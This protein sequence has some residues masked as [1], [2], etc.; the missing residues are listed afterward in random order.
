MAENKNKHGLSRYIPEA[1]KREVRQRCGFG[2]V[3]CG[4]GFY[5]YEHFNPDFADAKEHHP[6]G[7][8]LLCSQCNQKRARTRLSAE[9]VAEA[10]ENPVCL[11]RGFASEMFDFHREPITVT[12]A[13]CSFY[14][15]QHLILIDDQP[16]LSINSPEREKGPF[17]LS[18][19]FCD[20][21]GRE[22]LRIE[23]N[24]WI[25][26]PDNWDV[27]VEGPKIIIK[28]GPGDIVLELRMDPPKGIEIERLN[29]VYKGLHI[30]CGNNILEI[31]YN[32]GNW[33]R[34]IGCSVRHCYA[35]FIFESPKK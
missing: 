12:M 1:V 32:G 17:L 27:Q 3:R 18:G 29:M 14:A 23:K 16:V 11:D 20:E 26:K 9:T 22:I 2:C 7:I 31:S 21:K 34:W 6:D 19:V 5:D 25:V 4:H 13:G 8:T 30:R 35:G 24:E 28:N 10:N 15:C 33:S